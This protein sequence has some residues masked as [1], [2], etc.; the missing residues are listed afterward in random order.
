MGE[1][2]KKRLVGFSILISIAIIFVPIFLS[3]NN[4]DRELKLKIEPNSPVVNEEHV[5]RIPID[6]IES[7]I[8]ELRETS[9]RTEPQLYEVDTWDL[10]VGS[11]E[12]QANA[13]SLGSS[14]RE[15]GFAAYVR[16][17][18]QDDVKIFKVLVGPHIDL[19]QAE[20]VRLKL[21]NHHQYRSLLIKHVPLTTVPD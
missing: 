12:S 7:L 14:L 2:L 9:G 16:M 4:G 6:E 17:D 3:P 10:Q 8:Q 20:E 13:D 15:I 21:R 18:E 11:F 1:T 5:S 19:R